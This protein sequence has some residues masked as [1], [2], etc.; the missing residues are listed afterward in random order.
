MQWFYHFPFKEASSFL[1]AIAVGDDGAPGIHMP[2]LISFIN[3]GER[4]PISAE[5]FLLFGADVD[6]NSVI[7]TIIFWE[8]SLWPWPGHHA[9]NSFENKMFDYQ[10]AIKSLIF[11]LY[12]SSPLSWNIIRW[13]KINSR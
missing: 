9:R 3:D 7:V 4:I 2:V 12:P 5:Q 8:I 6:E 11:L 13:K 10:I 1:F